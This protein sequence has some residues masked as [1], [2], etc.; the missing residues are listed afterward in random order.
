MKKYL[1]AGL[2]AL[3]MIASAPA[4]SK[5]AG[6]WLIRGGVGNVDPDDDSWGETVDLDGTLVRLEVEVD[7]DTSFT[8]NFTYMFT[9]NWAVEVLAAWPFEHDIDADLSGASLGTIGST[10][11]IPPT[12]TAQYHFLPDSKIQPFVGVGVNMI[13]FYD[14]DAEGVL[15][16]SDLDIDTSFGL[17]AVVGADFMINDQWFIT[18]EIYWLGAEPD[19]EVDN[20]TVGGEVLGGKLD[21]DE[22][23]INPLV[24]NLMIGFRF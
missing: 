9:K 16:G 5:E 21:L 11:H 6:D 24:Y 20:L 12:V 8:T 10:K 19:G 7:D 22:I 14:E 4:F 3:G 18:G 13:Y 17:A 2:V 15:S 23:E 1:I